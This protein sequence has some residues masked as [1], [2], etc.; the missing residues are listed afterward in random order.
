MSKKKFQKVF[1]GVVSGV[2][3]CIVVWLLTQFG[4][5]KSFFYRFE[6]VTYDWRIRKTID[7]PVNQID[8]VIII[9]ID[10]RTLNKLGSFYQWSR[11][12]WAKLIQI[13]QEAG[14]RLVGLDIL[15]DPSKRFPREDA[16]F[17]Q[18]VKEY[19]QTVTSIVFTQADENNFL[20]PMSSEPE[21]LEV[22]RFRV[23]VPDE[24]MYRLPEYERMEPNFPQL[25][26]ASLA[27]G[28]V[29]LSSDDDGILRR[30]PLFLRFNDHV[31]PTLALAMMM[32]Y[33]DVNDIDYDSSTREVVLMTRLGEKI[34][35]PVDGQGRMLIHYYGPY[36]TFRYI[37][38]YSLI[39]ELY[40]L[41][42]ESKILE[43]F[44]DKVVLV[45]ASAPG[46]F[47]LR[48]IP[49]QPSFPGV[50]V[51]ANIFQQLME[52]RFIRELSGWESF[53]YLLFM[54]IVAG[55]LFG[56]A[57]PGR[58]M[59]VILNLLL[60]FL[61]LIIGFLTFA[62]KSIWFPMISPFL[63]VLLTFA[64]HYAYRYQAEEKDKRE[65]KRVF[66]HY[67]SA[68][69][70]DEMLKHPEKIKLGGEK[71][72]CTVLFTD[73]A[74]FTS[75]SEKTP[76]EKLVSLL[77]EYLNAMSKVILANHGT[78]DK[79]EGDAI[80]AIFGAPLEMP[81]HALKACATALHMAKRLKS[82]QADWKSRKLPILQ[83]RIGINSGEMV[84]GNMGSEI[85]FDY[86]AIGDA[87]NLGAR[88][89]SANKVYGTQILISE[90]TYHDV[91]EKVIT[92]QLDMIRVKG[93]EKPVK[94]YELI[95]LKS[96]SLDA[97]V[98]ELL[99]Y[100]QQGYQYY[101]AQKWEWAIHQFQQAL[102]VNP[103]DKPSQIFLM[104]CQKFMEHP[105]P[106]D[107]DG[108]YTLN[109]K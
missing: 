52:R 58:G 21:G 40:P 94:V 29:N 74:D 104:R 63:T 22:E 4:T 38:F 44:K 12:E 16:R 84:V 53:L 75:I 34:P 17:I 46:L 36:Q 37:S 6:A 95:A 67:V 102:K 9:D 48:S 69:V 71:K 83:Q 7:P 66:T 81:D 86:T 47:D 51:H 85:R 107:W 109:N 28:S 103:D 33:Y 80:M 15:F 100:F 41:K 105:P 82:L 96:D 1:S 87:V 98:Q 65:I 91:R 59:I 18:A 8:D 30:I 3:A 106:P 99:G 11:E 20:Y 70:V 27:I 54:G 55:L 43:Y 26:N 42:E 64:G 78:L 45:G 79:Y 10:G 60:M 19:G 61:I 93:R 73:L 101:L 24:L 90:F 89:E 76:P 39:Y 5:F 108:V 31:Y 13:L 14:V 25:S 97:N 23:N 50:E 56:L 2:G 72:Q 57:R 88:M 32:K 62:S 49:W 92:R 68:N 35:I 77:N